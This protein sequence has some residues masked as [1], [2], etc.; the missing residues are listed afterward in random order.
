VPAPPAELS[1]QENDHDKDNQHTAVA[2]AIC[3]HNGAAG[4]DQSNGR[5]VGVA[6][7]STSCGHMATQALILAAGR[8]SRLGP[9]TA[10]VPKPLLQV[11]PR[12]LVEHQLEAFSEAGIGPVG[13]VVG[14]QAD[15][16]A[17]VVGIR[18]EYISNNRW[19][20]TNSLY[21]F[22]QAKQWVRGDLIIANCDILLHPEIINRLVRTGGDAFAY[23]SGSGHGLEHMKVELRDHHLVRMSKTL[24]P[25]AVSGENVGL[26]YLKADSVQLLFTIAERII[27]EGGTKEWL[28]IAVQELGRHRKL[29]AVDVYGLPW[30]EIDFAFDLDR[31]R[32]Q[33][34][35]AI[36]GRRSRPRP[37]MAAIAGVAATTIVLVGALNVSKPAVDAQPWAQWDTANLNSD[38]TIILRDGERQQMWWLLPEG[39]ELTVEVCCSRNFRVESRVVLIGDAP[40]LPY[41]IRI[42][43]DREATDWKV[44]SARLGGTTTHESAPVSIPVY[45][46]VTIDESVSVFRIE[47]SAPRDAP[48]LVRIRVAQTLFDDET[49][50]RDPFAGLVA[51][52]P[53]GLRNSTARARARL[54]GTAAK[55]GQVGHVGPL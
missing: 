20:A 35:P 45:D 19:S 5:E 25:E 44:H 37:V 22:L 32:K 49:I 23:D 6:L 54:S 2:N 1:Y 3:D 24:P 47:G 26:L 33:V 15:E 36:R 55:L 38:G 51:D 48:I 41:S 42:A 4:A 8:G 18:A 13:M 12:T 39:K 11:G 29:R 50:A 21:S 40:A 31:A 46:Y 10:D 9:R 52:G 30:A 43:V 34:W 16:I 53:A 14:Y 27:D 7:I 28:G 17:E